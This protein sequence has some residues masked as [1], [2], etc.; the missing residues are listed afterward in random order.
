MDRRR[1]RGRATREKLVTVATELFAERGYEAT[2]IEAV[3]EH[4]GVSRG[5]LYHHF[6]SKE[7][8]FE[9]V[10]EEVEIRVGEA[11][12]SAAAEGG[13]TDRV[14]K[15]RL[16][17]M[18]WIRLAGDPVVRGILLIDAPSVLGW[19]RWREI[20]ERHALG[21]FKAVVHAASDEGRIAPRL[22]EPFS[23]M[24]IAAM[25][26]LALVIAL[27]DDVPAAQASAEAAI[28]EFL[29][30]LLPPPAPTATTRRR[31]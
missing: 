4:A 2:S 6:A 22:V 21:T 16:G 19:R 10:V 23:H 25:N 8:L 14:A 9:A 11:S 15:L 30:R 17:C 18:E 27:A 29:H 12:L 3:L 28:E 26:E 20:D 31:R 24:I 5:S 1:D 13:E 7:A